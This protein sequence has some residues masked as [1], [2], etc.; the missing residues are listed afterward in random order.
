M[1]KACM[2]TR[3]PGVITPVETLLAA[4]KRFAIIPALNTNCYPIFK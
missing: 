3:S 1:N 4:I 2:R